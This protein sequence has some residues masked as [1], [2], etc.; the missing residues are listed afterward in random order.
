MA[1]QMLVQKEIN[2]F[3]VKTKKLRAQKIQFIVLL[4]FY[5]F[6]CQFLVRLTITFSQLLNHI[7]V[8]KKRKKKEHSLLMNEY[9]RLHFSSRFSDAAICGQKRFLYTKMDLIWFVVCCD[10]SSLYILFYFIFHRTKDSASSFF[11]FITNAH[12]HT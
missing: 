1:L 4:L 8:L 11:C 3:I 9:Q 12:L 2:R 10:F 6:L 5:G 7:F